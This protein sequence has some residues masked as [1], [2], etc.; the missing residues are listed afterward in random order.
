MQVFFIQQNLTVATTVKL[1]ETTQKVSQ[2][3]SMWL[4]FSKTPILLVFWAHVI[5][6]CQEQ[7]EICH[8]SLTVFPSSELFMNHLLRQT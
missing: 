4:I 7:M 2:K 1:Q 8:Y 3:Y 5:A 6:L